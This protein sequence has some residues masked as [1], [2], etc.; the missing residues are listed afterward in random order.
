MM[1]C[2]SITTVLSFIFRG[3][4]T[5]SYNEN[6]KKMINDEKAIQNIRDSLIKA[7]REIKVNAGTKS[8]F[9][10]CFKAYH[11]DTAK[12]LKLT[13]EEIASTFEGAVFCLIL[14]ITLIA[15]IYVH[16]F[17]GATLK[18]PCFP[19]SFFT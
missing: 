9:S 10:I 19:A 8:Q 4:Q 18:R 17:G 2:L 7:E 6:A 3:R 14:W 11:T 15:A 16:L 5:K 1:L 13:P 12:E